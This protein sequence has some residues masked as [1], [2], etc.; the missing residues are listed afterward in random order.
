M[1][2]WIAI[3]LI[4][5]L[6]ACTT[7][8]TSTQSVWEGARI[9]PTPSATLPVN[10]GRPI[11]LTIQTGQPH[12]AIPEDEYT[13]PTPMPFTRGEHATEFGVQINGCDH[14]PEQYLGEIKA[15][16][17]TWVKQQVR[18]GDM[19]ARPGQIDWSCLDRLMTATR[20]HKLNVLLSVT[21]APAHL[22]AAHDTLGFPDQPEDFGYFVYALLRRYPKQVQAIELWNEPNI[23]AESKDGVSALRYLAFLTMGFGIVKYV[24]PS[25]LVI[26]AA[27]APV[28]TS[29]GVNVIADHDFLAK[30][31]EY[32]ALSR[33]DCIGAH[34]NGPEPSGNI[35]IVSAGYFDLAEQTRS[36]C[37]TEF[38]M[39]LASAD[40]HLP[41]NFAWAMPHTEAQQAETLAAGV[42]W[43]RDTGYVR[44]VIVWNWNYFTPNPDDANA[45][46]ALN[47]LGWRSPA[48]DAL[49][50]ALAKEDHK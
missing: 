24:D 29:Q 38:G 48:L 36:V 14:D 49:R 15:V 11:S 2:Q 22:R 13:L 16:G 44:L 34:A 50:A 10:Q 1:R 28:Q 35:E 40:G 17:F 47:R 26:S 21:T 5:A 25:I 33:L 42:R 27:P 30:L 23:D 32:D 6:T 20:K 9:M 46:Y 43:A 39:A 41:K 4:T 3:T 18:W 12:H 8:H 7:S 31:F 19:A 37:L 45:P